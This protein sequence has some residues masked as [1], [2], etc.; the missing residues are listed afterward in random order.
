[1]GAGLSSIG[2]AAA[3]LDEAARWTGSTLGVLGVVVSGIAIAG[4]AREIREQSALN[5]RLDAG[6]AQLNESNRESLA[7][8]P[9]N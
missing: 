7:P 3:Q 8:D 1:M 2:L 9:V 4:N 6:I 5:K